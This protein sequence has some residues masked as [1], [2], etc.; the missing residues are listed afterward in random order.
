MHHLKLVAVLIALAYVTSAPPAAAQ[1]DTAERP[2]WE[3]YFTAHD[4]EG[5]FVLHDVAAQRRIVYAPDRAA[6]PFVPASTFKIL[7]ALIALETGVVPDTTAI[8]PWD[9]VDRGW[10]RWNQDHTLGSAF[11]FSAVWVF[12]ALRKPSCETLY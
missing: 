12:Q 8:I 9:G 3:Q 11:Q 1:Y 2:D 10:E 6:T 7:H 5:T 4:V